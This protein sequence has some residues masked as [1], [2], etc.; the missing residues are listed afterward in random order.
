MSESARAT[1]GLLELVNDVKTDFDDGDKDHL[2]NS[3]SNLYRKGGVPPIPYRDKDLS[4]IVRIDEPDE[5]SEH[6]AVA[7]TKARPGQDDGCERW[8]L[9]VK[10]KAGWDKLRVAWCECERRFDQRTKVKPRRSVGGVGRQGKR[11]SQSFVKNLEL[12]GLH[13]KGVR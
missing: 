1:G 13:G 5:V 2:G 12:D 3:V 4:L 11:L 10:G 8:V 7:M 6:N 9:H